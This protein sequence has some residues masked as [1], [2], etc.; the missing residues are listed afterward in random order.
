MGFISPFI[1]SAYDNTYIYNLIDYFSTYM[2][3]N[4]ISEIGINDIIISF[5]H[6][7]QVNLK[8]YV[9]Y[10]DA[11]LHFTSQKLCTYFQ[12]K[13]I[14]VIFIPSIYHKLVG[15][16]EKSDEILQQAFKKMHEPGK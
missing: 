4:P 1:K 14:V 11:D 6:Y 15:I 12:K 10:I 16:I 5:H 7:L 8:P 2:Y 13:D 3:P 9:V